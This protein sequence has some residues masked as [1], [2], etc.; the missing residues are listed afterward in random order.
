MGKKSFWNKLG[1]AGKKAGQVGLN[2]ARVAGPIA[3]QIAAMRTGN[4]QY[5]MM[6]NMLGGLGRRKRFGRRRVYRRRR[7]YRRR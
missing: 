2:I 4:P 6:G 1:D 5:V 3:G 7:G